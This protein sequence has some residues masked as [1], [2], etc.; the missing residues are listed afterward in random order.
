MMN[1]KGKNRP[2]NPTVQLVEPN[3][4]F[5]LSKVVLSKWLGE[6]T[7]QFEFKQLENNQTEFVQTWVGKG[8]LVK[9]M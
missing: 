6:L 5:I 2:F 4:R 7:H 8:I 9:M 3:K 1:V